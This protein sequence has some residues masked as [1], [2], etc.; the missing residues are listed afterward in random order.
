MPS[1]TILVNDGRW[2]GNGATARRAAE[3]T[4]KKEKAKGTVNVLLAD[5]AEVQ[6][7]NRQYRA[8]DKP[9]NVLSFPDGEG[10]HIGDIILA[11]ETVAREAMEQSKSLKHHLTH[12]V[13]HGVLHLLGYDHETGEEDAE[14][15]EHK[16]VMLLRTMGI[17]NPYEE[18]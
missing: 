4:L 3:A 7:L 5:D 13:V 15:M 10:D 9:T 14:I 2:K 1:I 18:H 6:E 17:A 8:K 12:L 16:E 11:Y